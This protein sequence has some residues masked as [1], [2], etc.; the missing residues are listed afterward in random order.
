M[1]LVTLTVLSTVVVAVLA[2]ELEA[3]VTLDLAAA[4]AQGLHL[5]RERVL[6]PHLAIIVTSVSITYRRGTPPTGEMT[7]V[8]GSQVRSVISALNSTAVPRG[9]LRHRRLRLLGVS[10]T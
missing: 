9:M 5:H 1:R 4:V 10:N 3:L 6:H 2:G 8:C 7:T